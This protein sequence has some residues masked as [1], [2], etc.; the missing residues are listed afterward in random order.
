MNFSPCYDYTRQ[1]IQQ[2]APDGQGIYR[3]SIS[4]RI[5]YI[6]KA[7]N[8]RR[9]LI[10]HLNPRATNHLVTRYLKKYRCF[11]RFA[12]VES[13]YDLYVIERRQINKY[14][15]PCNIDIL[16]LEKRIRRPR[17]SPATTKKLKENHQCH[18]P[19]KP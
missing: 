13:A 1:N 17:L 18:P 12:L 7:V 11:F 8:L 2:Q 19:L 15:P 10:E 5:F 3:L 14:G 4:N 6:G 16:T 9:R